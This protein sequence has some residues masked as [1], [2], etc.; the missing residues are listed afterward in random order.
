MCVCVR[1]CVRVYVCVYIF[2]CTYLLV[3]SAEAG[4]AESHVPP[5]AAALQVPFASGVSPQLLNI[6]PAI[7][8]YHQLL[9]ILRAIGTS[10]AAT[11]VSPRLLWLVGDPC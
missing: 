11:R 7:R 3:L 5:D 2:T 1:V 8:I 10:T 4:P 6:P 9:H